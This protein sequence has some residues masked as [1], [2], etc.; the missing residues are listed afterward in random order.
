MAQICLPH[1][2]LYCPPPVRRNASMADAWPGRGRHASLATPPLWTAALH[3]CR[4]Q[5]GCPSPLAD[6]AV[7]PVLAHSLSL[8]SACRVVTSHARRA[9]Q[10]SSSLLPCLWPSYTHAST[11]IA[12]PWS[13]HASPTPSAGVSLD[14]RLAVGDIAAGD[15]CSRG[16]ASLDHHEASSGHRGV[17]AG[18]LALP[19]Y[20][21]VADVV[22]N[23]RRR[24]A[25]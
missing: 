17:G 12:F 20:F 9:G 18:P 3:P 25:R 11:T 7:A 2:S 10:P 24:R 23:H 5:R 8:Q 1:W 4:P 15:N 19:H 14:E 13:P 22:P 21:S 16:L 6:S